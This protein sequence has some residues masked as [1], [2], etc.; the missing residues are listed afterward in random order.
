MYSRSPKVLLLVLLAGCAN[1]KAADTSSTAPSV[2]FLSPTDGEE[3]A[4]SEVQVSLLIE[5]FTLTTPAAKA[6]GP[7]WPL[8]LLPGGVAWAHSE[9]GETPEGYCA[10]TLD[11]TPVVNLSETQHTLGGLAGGE[12]TLGAQLYY[13]DGDPLDEPATAEVT[14]SVAVAR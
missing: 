7:Q 3:L 14:F 4:D 8:L 1:D 11:G 2:S 9:E 5:N 6:S 10:L 13:A 12:H